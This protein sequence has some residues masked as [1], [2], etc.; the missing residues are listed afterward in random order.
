MRK[1]VTA[2]IK[3]AKACS[4]PDEQELYTE[5]YSDGAGGSEY[6]A[7]TRAVEHNMSIGSDGQVIQ[8]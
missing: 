2:A 5:I 7:F 4:L 3:A 1:E 6:P 8:A